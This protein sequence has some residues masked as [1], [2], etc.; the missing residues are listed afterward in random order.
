MTTSEHNTYYLLITVNA[1]RQILIKSS[2]LKDTKVLY[3]YHTG[4]ICPWASAVNSLYYIPLH[5]NNPGKCQ[6]LLV[7]ACQVQNAHSE[8]YGVSHY[9]SSVGTT[10]SIP[11]FVQG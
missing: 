3:T 8:I 6:H 2:F 4:C 11:D 1:G 7:K 5:T 10:L 9:Q